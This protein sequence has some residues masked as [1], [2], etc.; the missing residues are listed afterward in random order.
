MTE[1]TKS[2][3]IHLHNHNPQSEIEFEVYD[4]WKNGSVHVLYLGTSDVTA[5]LNEE[6][7]RSLSRTLNE[8]VWNLDVQQAID[9]A[10]LPDE[11]YDED[12]EGN[13]TDVQADADTLASAGWGTDE[14]YL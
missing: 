13:W 12:Y 5:F 4:L 3:S 7:V 9:S 14:D 10:E 2:V 8:Y 11:D 1:V 6:Q